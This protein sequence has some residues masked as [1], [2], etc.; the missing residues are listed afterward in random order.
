MRVVPLLPTL[1]TVI[2]GGQTGVDRAALDW[3][4]EHDLPH[5]GWCPRGRRAEDGVIPR[6]YH[7]QETASSRY[8][9]RTHRN[10]LDSDGTLILNLGALDGGTSLIADICR[11]NRKPYR[12][13][14]ID[15]GRGA[16]DIGRVRAWCVAENIAVLN[17]S[18][19][20]ESK[21]PGAYDAARE[22]L[23]LL[24]DGL[25]RQPLP[26]GA[27]IPFDRYG[28]IEEQ[29]S[30]NPERDLADV[31]LTYTPRRPHPRRWVRPP[32]LRGRR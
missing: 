27:A 20:R 31:L 16:R 1:R 17:V 21:R 30:L 29:V 14:R 4:I 22:F 24:A 5:G 10:V 19:P 13:V 23:R 28:E 9:P 6:H 11:R 3:A 15:A 25:A 7:L 26:R 2:C 32:P 18:G 8:E 12:V